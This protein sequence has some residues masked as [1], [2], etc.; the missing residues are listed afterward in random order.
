MTATVTDAAL[1]L[2]KSNFESFPETKKIDRCD[3]CSAQAVITFEYV[4]N[5]AVLGLCA[6]HCIKEGPTGVSNLQFL[7]GDENFTVVA[8]DH[9]NMW[10]LD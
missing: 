3:A 9:K 10:F 1:T 8:A 2:T 5:G 7:L 4:K 6:Y